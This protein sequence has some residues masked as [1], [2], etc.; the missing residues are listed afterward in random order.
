MAPKVAM[1]LVVRNEADVID[2][3]IAFHLNAGVDLIIVTDNG[4][5]DGTAEILD[6]YARAGHVLWSR[7]PSRSISQI[8]CVTEMARRAATEFAATWVINSDADEFWWPRGGTLKE[9]FAAIPPRFGSVRGMWRHFVPRP[10]GEDFFAERMTVRLCKP[11]LDRQHVFNPH[12]KTAHRATPDVTVGGGNHDVSGPGLLPLRGWFPIDILHFPLRSLEQCERKYVQHYEW[13]AGSPLGIK[14]IDRHM[15]DAY[16]AYQEGRMRAFYESD[17]AE[18]TRLA[19]GLADGTYAWDTRLRDAMRALCVKGSH[20]EEPSESLL[21][22]GVPTVDESYVWEVGA[23]GDHD[24]LVQATR[25][26]DELEARLVAGE[27]VQPRRLLARLRR[28]IP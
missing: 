11:F 26:V 23:L 19:T 13:R 14:T 17:L 9:I 24:P 27:A 16:A 25:R 28:A 5:D 21:N 18:G 20:C 12:F 10:A 7:N 4:S 3:Q 2:A 6:S 1:T 22:F 15:A 8:D